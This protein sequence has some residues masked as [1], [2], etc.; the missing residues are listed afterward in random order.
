M[1]DLNPR[2]DLDEVMSTLLI[3][4]E[5]CRSRV[6]VLNGVGEL[7]GVVQDGLTSLFGQ[8]RCRG[9]FDDLPGCRSRDP[10]SPEVYA[11]EN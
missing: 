11:L 9:D 2:V 6:T 1:L 3:D 7:D 4:Q 8:V 5:L 10:I